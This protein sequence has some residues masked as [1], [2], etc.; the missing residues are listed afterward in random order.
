MVRD[1]NRPALLDTIARDRG[2]PLTP[3]VATLVS[4][5]MDRWSWRYVHPIVAPLT[6]AIVAVLIVLKRLFPL[7]LSNHDLIDRLGIWF[8]RRFISVEGNILLIRH[9]VVESNLLNF[10]AANCGRSGIELVTLRPL[11]ARELGGHAVIRHDIN[12]YNVMLDLAEAQETTGPLAQRPL[13]ALDFSMLDIPAIDGGAAD[14]KWLSL[15]LATGLCAM[16]VLFC[17]FTTLPEYER[18][19]NSFQLDES[20]LGYIA[21]ITGDPVFRSWPPK[22]FLAGPHLFR[23]T[24]RELS[25]HAIVN[26][27]AHGRLLQMRDALQAGRGWPVLTVS[28][29]RH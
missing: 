1:R 12:I 9:F 15:D 5:D 3:D 19:V 25:W 27:F 21:E 24:P 2:V 20:L 8:L 14:D 4:R 26:E 10:V 16:N 17:L 18:A 11:S 22:R 7:Q 23:N 13:S 29:P 28:C 6:N